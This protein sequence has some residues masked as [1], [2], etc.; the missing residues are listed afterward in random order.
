MAAGQAAA[1]KLYV[2]ISLIISLIHIFLQPLSMRYFYRRLAE[3]LFVYS[4]ITAQT[5]LWRMDMEKKK[6]NPKMR[7]TR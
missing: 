7:K 4:K 3:T 5:I 1:G 6:R 2:K